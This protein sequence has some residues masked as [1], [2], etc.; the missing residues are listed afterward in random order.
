MSPRQ[1]LQ[2][3]PFLLI[4]ALAIA[5]AAQVPPAAASDSTSDPNVVTYKSVM[6]AAKLPEEVIITKIQ[7]AKTNFDLSTS[8][9]LEPKN[10]SVSA[11]IANAIMTPK[12][13]QRGKKV[14]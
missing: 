9:L 14:S 4:V 13:V 7:T 2:F 12:S 6:V 3:V 1:L 10:S 11:N 8:A 5:V